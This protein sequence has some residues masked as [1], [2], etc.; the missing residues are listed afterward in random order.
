MV[1]QRYDP[2]ILISV[3]QSMVDCRR[4]RDA[5]TIKQGGVVTTFGDQSVKALTDKKMKKP[6]YSTWVV[7]EQS[8]NEFLFP[9]MEKVYV[10]I[11]LFNDPVLVA[12]MI[13]QNKRVY[14]ALYVL[15]FRVITSSAA[16]YSLINAPLLEFWHAL[17]VLLCLT[18]KFTFLTS[19]IV[20]ILTIP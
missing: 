14:S 5:L 6:D 4:F 17:S 2:F 18:F 9:F 3:L 1:G 7:V 10:G 11:Q 19:D 12:A 13:R 15:Q 16:R 20:W 8:L